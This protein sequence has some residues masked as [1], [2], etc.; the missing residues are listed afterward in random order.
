MSRGLDIDNRDD[1][2]GGEGAVEED[3]ERGHVGQHQPDPVSRPDTPVLEQPRDPARPLLELGVGQDH[4]VEPHGR[5]V[6]VLLGGL[7]EVVGQVGHE[8][9]QRRTSSCVGVRRRE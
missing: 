8:R 9:L 7:G 4:V 2:A 1:R 3:G 6:G 5:S